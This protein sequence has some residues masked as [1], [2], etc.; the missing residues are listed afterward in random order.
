M[1]E[2]RLGLAL[3]KSLAEVRA[4]PYPEYRS[5]QLFYLAEPWGWQNDEYHFAALL[6]MLYNANRGKKGKARDVKDFMRNMQEAVLKELQ[7][8]PDISEMTR[9]QII[10]MVKRDFGIR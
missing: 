8:A 2:H 7:D 5:W 10:A 1:F 4:L 6:A 9:E 3:G